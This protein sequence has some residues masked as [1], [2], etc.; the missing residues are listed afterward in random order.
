MVWN[1]N[2]DFFWTPRENRMSGKNL[3]HILRFFFLRRV[4]LFEWSIQLSAILSSLVRQINLILHILITLNGLNNLADIWLMLDHSKVTKM[5]FWMIQSAKKQVFGRFLDL[6]LLD[7]LDIA[8]FDRTICFPTFGNTT[9]SWSIIQKSPK[10]IFEWCE[11]PKMRLLA[12]ILS[13]VCWID[14]ILHMM[15]E[16]YVFH[17]SATLP[18]HE[19]SFKSLKKA[20]L[21]DPKCQILSLVC[22]IDLIFCIMRGVKQ[23]NWTTCY[24]LTMTKKSRW[25]QRKWYAK[26]I[27]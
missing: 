13:L 26:S 17:H 1:E 21:N 22:R 14:L 10:S 8:Y 20:F 27:L 15:I 19:G 11:V 18:G 4:G 25:S 24:K 16:F 3:E 23:S 5:H 12:I 9:R 7:R 2:S 6:G